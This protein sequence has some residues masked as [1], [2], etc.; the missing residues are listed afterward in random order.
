M[1]SNGA[2]Y[3]ML[4]MRLAVAII[5]IAAVSGYAVMRY[6]VGNHEA[7]IKVTEEDQS[8]IKERLKGIETAQEAQLRTMTDIRNEMRR[9]HNSGGGS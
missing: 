4:D 3:K 7:R 2:W 6:Q 8:T 1:A 5:L 9:I